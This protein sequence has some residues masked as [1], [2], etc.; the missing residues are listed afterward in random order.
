MPQW[1]DNPFPR[2]HRRPSSVAAL[3][4]PAVLAALTS[5]QADGGP[6]E[7]D[8][9]WGLVLWFRSFFLPMDFSSTAPMATRARAASPQENVFHRTHGGRKGRPQSD[10]AEG[11][12]EDGSGFQVEPEAPAPHRQLSPGGSVVPRPAGP[13][14]GRTR[15]RP[16]FPHRTHPEPGKSAQVLA[17]HSLWR[18]GLA[19]AS[20]GRLLAGTVKCGSAFAHL[21]RGQSRGRKHTQLGLSGPA[22]P[23]QRPRPHFLMLGQREGL[24]HAAHMISRAPPVPFL[25]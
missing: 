3:S 18:G 6:W 1:R 13:A 8:R 2:D 11:H 16:S 14:P 23:Q 17:A 22:P 15:E 9:S 12:T 20:C 19:P 24:A 4:Q 10:G 5:R 7:R 25:L 21:A